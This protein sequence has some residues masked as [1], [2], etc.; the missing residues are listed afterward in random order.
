M[1]K[2]E[3]QL[4][5]YKYTI[6]VSMSTYRWAKKKWPTKDIKIDNYLNNRQLLITK[7]GYLHNSKRKRLV[8]IDYETEF[9]E[10]KRAEIAIRSPEY[11]IRKNKG[12]T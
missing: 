12:N 11:P 7:P 9:S 3:I 1:R 4:A 10:S 5:T 8:R 2:K 6:W